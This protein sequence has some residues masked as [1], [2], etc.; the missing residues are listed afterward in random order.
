MAS[1]KNA[2]A[3]QI[4][5]EIALAGILALLVADRDERISDDRT[6]RKTELV[7]GDAGVPAEVIAALI[8]KNVSAVKKSIERARHS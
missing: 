2:S 5:S 7:L 1:S 8:G 6:A 4:P 3:P